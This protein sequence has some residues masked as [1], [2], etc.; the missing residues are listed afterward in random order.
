MAA[1]CVDVSRSASV[2]LDL[3]QCINCL[4]CN[5]GLRNG[6]SCDVCDHWQH[7]RCAKISEDEIKGYESSEWKCPVYVLKGM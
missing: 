3:I 2:K 1:V 6:I 4:K 5:K 7:F